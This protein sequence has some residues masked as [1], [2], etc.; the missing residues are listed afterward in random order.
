MNEQVLYFGP[1]KSLVGIVTH[2]SEA[3]PG[4]P[5]ILL[6]NA[7]IIHRIGPNRLYV[8][9]ARRLADLGFSVLRFDFAGVGDSRT[10]DDELTVVERA[11]DNIRAAMDALGTDTGADRFVTMGLCSGAFAG[12]MAA[13]AEERVVGCVQLDGFVYPTRGYYLRRYGPKLLS[14][15]SW[16][17]FFRSR[18]G[19]APGP[20]TAPEHDAPFA[21]VMIPRE[22]FESDV[23]ALVARRTHLLFVLTRGGLQDVNY[24]RQLH[25]S[26]PTVDL[27]RHATVR[28]YPDAD[29]TFTN[30]RYRL[31]MVD[32]VA[33]WI[34]T[35]FPVNAA[36]R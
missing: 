30:R 24:S 36:A 33:D 16:K 22:Q 13:V 21:A 23:Q 12:H 19:K 14:P 5:A 15:S 4:A 31:A 1:E 2:P 17:T 26:V 3:R 8:T 10:T 32:E 7:G 9:L 25:D 27:D 18:L 20:A 11:Q 34:D 6:L 35:T 28:Y 29:H